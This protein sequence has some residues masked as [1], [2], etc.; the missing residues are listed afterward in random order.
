MKT[1]KFMI[2]T[3]MLLSILLTE[4]GCGKQQSLAPVNELSFSLD[5][6]AEIIISYDDEDVR[7]LQSNNDNLVIKEYMSKNKDS[8]HANVYQ[9]GSSIKISEGGK[10]FF[11]DGFVRRIEVYLPASYNETLKVTTTDGSIDITSM[12]PDMKSLRIDCT[13][14][15]VKLNEAIASDIY[16]SSTSG[17]LDLGAIKADR[18][19]IDTTKGSVVCKRIEGAVSYTSTGGNAEFLSAVGSGTYTSNNSGKLSVIYEEVTG[20]LSLYNKNDN[21]ELTLPSVLEFEFEAITKN[22][23]V[24]TNFQENLSANDNMA[25]GTVGENP[26]VTVKAETKNGNI[27][28]TRQKD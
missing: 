9:K 14:G 8:Y 7:F 27:E 19:R 26:T 17:K 16:L 12:V 1:G 3:A 10:P 23:S 5:G 28:V 4:S 24:D 6:I 21:V 2:L 13:S 22:G 18:I 20:D 25:S 15:V 11:K